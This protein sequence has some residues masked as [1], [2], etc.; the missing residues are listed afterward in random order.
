MSRVTLQTI[1][2]QLG[3]SR[4]TVSNAFSR[5]DQLSAELRRRILASADQLGYIGPHPTARALARGSS[6][7]VGVLS[8][9]PFRFAFSDDVA[10]RFIGAVAEELEPTGLALTLFTGAEVGGSFPARDVVI[11]GAMVYSSNSESPAIE[12]L[13]R[14][15]LPLVFVDQPPDP[16]VACVNIDDRSGGRLAA[17]HLLDLGHR[18]IG[19]ITPAAPNS[20]PSTGPS[21]GGDALAVHVP[22]AASERLAGWFDELRPAGA[23]VTAVFQSHPPDQ[24]SPAIRRLLG[25]PD[26]PTAVLCYSDAIALLV[27]REAE[28][29]GLRVP[30]ELSVVGFDNSPLMQHMGLSLTT[31]HQ[32]IAAKGRLAAAILIQALGKPTPAAGRAGAAPPRDVAGG[33]GGAPQHRPRPRHRPVGLAEPELRHRRPADGTVGQ[34]SAP[35]RRFS[36]RR[37]RSRRPTSR[38]RPGCGRRAWSSG[39]PGGS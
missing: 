31:I 5:P 28:A 26:R 37:G 6:G 12:R 39:C 35:G 33:A 30:E 18:R 22:Y 7:A 1:A 8:T 20:G 29:L 38:S 2:D 32:D 27:V 4:M 24:G 17:R 34:S 36:R 13:R 25:S 16:A 3:V 21:E 9:D 10:A 19:F 15:G 23:E 11:D 14:R